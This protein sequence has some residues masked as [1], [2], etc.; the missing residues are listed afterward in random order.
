MGGRPD[1]RDDDGRNSRWLDLQLHGPFEVLSG[2]SSAIL[3]TLVTAP[4][5]YQSVERLASPGVIY[6]GEAIAIGVVGL[7]VNLACAWLLRGGHRHEHH[8]HDDCAHG[9][10]HHQDLNLRSAYV[11]VVADA[12]T[13][14]LVIVALFVGKLWARRGSTLPW[15]SS[16]P[17]W[18]QCGPM[19]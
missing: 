4:M 6:N 14:V 9:H 8:G 13:S 12:A 7:L 10:A 19:G 5:L 2:S 18:L 17:G 1:R 16:V 3:L 11:H 15:A